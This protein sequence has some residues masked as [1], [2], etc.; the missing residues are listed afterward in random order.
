ME[1]RP[2]NIDKQ[3]ARDLS[4]HFRAKIDRI[5]SDT[6]S[7][8]DVVLDHKISVAIVIRN[9]ISLAA[10]YAIAAQIDNDRFLGICDEIYEGIEKC[11]SR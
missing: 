3:I 9:L 8:S 10:F 1:I 11:P 5:A 6:L 2:M 7:T 4:K